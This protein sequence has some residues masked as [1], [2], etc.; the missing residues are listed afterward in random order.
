MSISVASKQDKDCANA[1]GSVTLSVGSGTGSLQVSLNGGA[2]QTGLTF[3]N[4]APNSYTATAKDVSNC[5]QT[6]NFS[7]LD[8]GTTPSAPNVSNVEY[9]Q[10]ATPSVLTANGTNLKWYTAATGGTGDATAPTPSTATVGTVSYWVSSVNGLCESGR[11]KIDVTTR[12]LPTISCVG[13][14][15][16]NS[17][18]GV[19]GKIITY[20][21]T[22]TGA[23]T[24]TVTYKF[25]G[26]TT[27]TGNGNGSGS[28]FNVGV[29]TVT[30][31]ATNSCSTVSCSFTV[32]IDGTPT[33]TLGTIPLP[34]SL[35]FQMAIRNGIIFQILA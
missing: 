17:A 31:T 33:L 10:N 27:G 19:C 4:L 28:F 5:T 3:N 24:P 29:T 26:A 16:D 12:A 14:L 18:V 23:P 25:E 2:Y 9:C 20:N 22:V 7:I 21:S 6:V 1:T 15:L 13:N 30:L 8:N 34:M 11:S 35:L 32:T